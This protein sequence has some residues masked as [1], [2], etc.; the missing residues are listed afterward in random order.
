MR[1]AQSLRSQ[2]RGAARLTLPLV[3]IGIEPGATTTRSATPRPCELDTAEVTSRLNGDELI[4]RILVG[5]AAVLEFDDGGELLGVS[6]WMCTRFQRLRM[7]LC[8][9]PAER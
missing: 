6:G 8:M 9:K 1:V 3:V 5:V 2:V 7:L 4:R